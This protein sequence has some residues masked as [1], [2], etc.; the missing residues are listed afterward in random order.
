MPS[1]KRSADRALRLPGLEAAARAGLFARAGF[2]LVLAALVADMAVNGGGRQTNGHGA[3]ELVASTAIG[4]VL[5]G[6]AALGFL[7]LGLV[8][9][10]AALRD[11]ASD[12]GSRV[13]TGLQGGFYCALTTVPVSFLAGKRSTGSEQSQHR[14][15]GE[16][17]GLPGGR[18]IV[19]G[20]ALILIGICLWQIRGAVR[21]DFA[22]G[23]RLPPRHPWIRELTVWSGRAGIVAR[24]FTFLPV[25]GFLIAAAVDVNPGKADGL[26]AELLT[27]SHE[28]W[29]SPVLWAIV[30][31]LLTFAVYSALEATYRDLTSDR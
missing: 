28:P 13:T 6:F 15:A 16:V 25:G 19:F 21:T 20:V 3:L 10:A 30:A 11:R 5:I 14:E 24:A 1:A 18:V 22:D 4:E 2:Y 9:I 26:D 7:L 17:L 8:R 29:G 27:L 23:L 31:G 12:V